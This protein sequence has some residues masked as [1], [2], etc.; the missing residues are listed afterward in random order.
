MKRVLLF[1]L[2]MVSIGLYAQKTPVV[3][4][5]LSNTKIINKDEAVKLALFP[6]YPTL[7]QASLYESADGQLYFEIIYKKDNVLMVD[8][9]NITKEQL[10][11][12]RQKIQAEREISLKNLKGQPD[13]VR[14]YN[15]DKNDGRLIFVWGYSALTTFFYGTALPIAIL[16][17]G[18]NGKQAAGAYLL[19][20]GG[21]IS[22]LINSTK[23][24]EI[25]KAEAGLS[26]DYALRG[27]VHG[28]LIYGALLDIRNKEMIPLLM[29]LN[30]IAEGT[31]AFNIADK[32]KMNTGQSSY[33]T[34]CHDIVAGE[35]AF[36]ESV[37]L[38]D[39]ISSDVMVLS[40]LGAAATGTY[41]GFLRSRSDKYT[42]GDVHAIKTDI[43]IGI[44]LA[45]TATDLL[46]ANRSIMAGLITTGLAG[47]YLYGEKKALSRDISTN[48]GY[49]LSLY[50]TAGSLI[51]YGT[52]LLFQSENK[53]NHKLNMV[54][55]SAGSI[56]GYYFYDRKIENS[57]TG[58]NKEKDS[59]FSLDTSINPMAFNTKNSILNFRVNF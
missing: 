44:G 2:M 51:G 3:I 41:S 15:Q 52:S 50:S 39:R 33:I 4:D 19:I 25:S 18:S 29:T 7:E 58:S 24:K 23:D 31:I 46:D 48:D 27:I 38:E 16:S 34:M 59:K 35:T 36:L 5:S 17:D 6:E 54:L 30:S 53:D 11:V 12:I 42:F 9:Y 37:F 55:S 49:F 20:T 8:R 43:G 28:S 40:I 32:Y 45:L 21:T 10:A 1:V 14:E 26:L 56:A 13:W 47:G 22:F 57:L